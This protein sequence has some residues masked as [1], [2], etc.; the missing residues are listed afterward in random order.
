MRYVVVL[1][2]VVACGGGSKPR[3]SPNPDTTGSRGSD[4]RLELAEISISEGAMSLLVHADGAIEVTDGTERKAIGTLSEDG[5]LT[6]P[7]GDV[8]QLQADGSFTTRD[9]PLSFTLRDETLVVGDLRI[10]FDDQN[11]IRGAKTDLSMTKVKG[12]TN[13]GT[14]R[15]ALLMLGFML[16]K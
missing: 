5:K 8:G 3:T 12:V 13:R 6:L 2:L 7:D 15:T 4:T 11:V 9:G 14:R 10:T 16:F 1:A